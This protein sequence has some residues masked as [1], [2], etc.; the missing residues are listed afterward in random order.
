M[1]TEVGTKDSLLITKFKVQAS[2]KQKL[3]NGQES[4]KK[5]TSKGRANK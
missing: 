3:T 2:I 4:G 5:D 1:L